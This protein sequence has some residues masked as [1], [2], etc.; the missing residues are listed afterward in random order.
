M[1][2]VVKVSEPVVASVICS[3]DDA[4]ENHPTHAVRLHGGEGLTK[5]CAVRKAPIL[6]LLFALAIC[7][8]G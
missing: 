2:G 4:V 8:A 3:V 1:V 7:S 5:K 6:E